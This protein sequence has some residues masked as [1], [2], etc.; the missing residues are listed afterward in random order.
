MFHSS[1]SREYLCNETIIINREL[2][3]GSTDFV[4]I[5]TDSPMSNHFCRRTLGRS[6]ILGL[7]DVVVIADRQITT[8]SFDTNMS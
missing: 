5:K 2:Y 8:K 6:E 3:E 4:L 1:G 7:G